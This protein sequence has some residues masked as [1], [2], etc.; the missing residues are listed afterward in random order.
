MERLLAA[1]RSGARAQA[2]V[3]AGWLNRLFGGKL[4]PATVTLVGFA[5]HL[6][7]AGLIAIGQNYWA[8]GLLVVFGLFDILDGALARL[9]GTSSVRGMLLDASTDR[10]KE[11]LLYSGAGFAL[12][13]SAQPTWAA[14]AAT[15][16][17]ASLCVSYV[18]AKGEAAVASGTAKIPHATLNRMFADG[19]MTFEVRMAVLVAGLLTGQLGWA[20]VFIAVTASI[21]AV[22]RLV[23]ISRQ[24]A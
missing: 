23:R 15:A 9:Q 12:A 19:L 10:M 7:I 21:T 4:T 5:M 20:V 3:V 22:M 17:G 14:W 18:K 13:S 2:T 8:A 16:V 24:L 1:I 11:V 6:P